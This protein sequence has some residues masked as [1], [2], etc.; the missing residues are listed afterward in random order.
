MKIL[1][2]TIIPVTIVATAV[3]AFTEAKAQAIYKSVDADGNITYTDQPPSADAQPLDLPPITVA[4]PYESR[5]SSSASSDETI[6][7][8]VPY[9]DFALLSPTQEQH[10]WGTG[11]SFTAQ[12]VLSQPLQPGHLV[13]FLL[14]GA[15]A[16]TGTGFFMEFTNI[17]RGEHTIQAEVVTVVGE[18]LARTDPVVFFMRQQSVIN[19]ARNN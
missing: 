14:D 15:V 9:T 12:A 5:I 1:N 19:R 4:D 13:R 10:F 17:D 18:V 16:G 7:D 8:L 11:G 3:L 2:A 6:D